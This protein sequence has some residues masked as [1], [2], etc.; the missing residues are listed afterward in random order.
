M[1]AQTNDSKNFV[2][3]LSKNF[4]HL[5]YTRHPN[6]GKRRQSVFHMIKKIFKNCFRATQNEKKS[7][8]KK[9]DIKY[10]HAATDDMS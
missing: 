6:I 9:F 2:E 8:R 10:L 5:K 1:P 7:S 4:T 3:N